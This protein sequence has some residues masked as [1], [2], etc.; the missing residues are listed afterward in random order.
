MRVGVDSYTRD[1]ATPAPTTV[2]DETTLVDSTSG[3]VTVR[4]GGTLVID[5][6]HEGA[7]V[8]E[9]GGTLHVA[10]ALYGSLEIGS[11]ATARVAGD[12]IGKVEIRVA[13]TLVVEAGGRLAGPVVNYGSFTNHGVRSGPIEGRTPDDRDGSVRVAPVHPGVYNLTLPDRG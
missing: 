4:D 6:T 9:G 13:G 8:L 11:L 1:M 2:T 7:V 5:G 3:S 12:L 10:G